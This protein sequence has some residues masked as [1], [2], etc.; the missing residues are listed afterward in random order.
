LRRAGRPPAGGGQRRAPADIQSRERD[1]GNDGARGHGPGGAVVRRTKPGKRLGGAPPRPGRWG[2][3]VSGK[4]D[5]RSRRRGLVVL[6]LVALLIIGAAAAYGWAMDVQLR[7]GILRQRAEAARRPDWVQLIALPPYVG[8]AFL[9]VTDPAFLQRSEFDAGDGASLARLLVRQVHRLDD[10]LS[11]QMHELVMG[12]LLETH[13]TKRAVL[14]LYLN[15]VP[16][17]EH[18]GAP[19]FG[20]YHAA[21][22]YFG[23]APQELTLGEAATLAG[24]LLPPAITDPASHAGAVGA[25]RN[26]VLQQMLARGEITTEAYRAALSEPLAFQPGVRFAPM[27]R[28]ANW[29]QAPPVIRIEPGPLPDSTAG[30]QPR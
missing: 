16:L 24:L 2:R 12:P 17:G 6:P 8:Q 11:G 5:P 10:H 1:G 4:P 21:H 22:A 26:E 18:D 14:E 27:T 7:H 20:I 13:L 15:R 3:R 25:R 9:A 30:P 28:P 23:K 19:V 29:E